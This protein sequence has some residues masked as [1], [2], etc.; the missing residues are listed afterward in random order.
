MRSTNAIFNGRA[1]SCAPPCRAIKPCLTFTLAL[2]SLVAVGVVA[3]AQELVTVPAGPTGIEGS[4]SGVVLHANRRDPFRTLFTAD[5]DTAVGIT[6]DW[7]DG[8]DLRELT[9]TLDEPV[10]NRPELDYAFGLGLQ[11]AQKP[12]EH[13]HTGFKALAV[14]TAI[15][16]PPI[17]A[18][19]P[20]G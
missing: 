16:L 6:A 9:T 15:D 3:D 13:G 11:T 1:G 17:R 18:V 7:T 14:E 5:S 19:D 2:M 10:L 8:T 12:P 4:P 20:R